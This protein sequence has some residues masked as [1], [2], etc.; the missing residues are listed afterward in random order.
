MKKIWNYLKRHW[1]EDYSSFSYGIIIAMLI[2]LLVTNYSID[3]E[4]NIL[5]TKTGL[6]KFVYYLLFYSIPYY[7]T[8]AIICHKDR[9]WS[10]KFI[11]KSAFG[12]ILLATDASLPFLRPMLADVDPK[13]YLWTY[14]VTVNLISLFTICLP[15]F[16]YYRLA[17]KKLENFYG[18]TPRK[19][20]YAP[21]LLMLLIMLPLILGATML[22]GFLKQYP[23]YKPNLAHELLGVPSIVT[24]LSYELAYGLDFVTVELFFRGF[25]VIGMAT[26]LGRKSVL[27]MA[28]IYCLLHFGKP[29]GE[30]MSSVVGGYIL[31]VIAFETKS[32]WGGVIV[33]VGI[34]WMMELVSYIARH[35]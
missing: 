20:D 35:Y 19:F 28:V 27:A 23:M 16:V 24:A 29:A 25:M 30:A 10:G 33:H 11:F 7:T 1:S 13:L 12:L 5:D 15:L 8:V 17:D 14:K 3:F 18:L 9:I 32:I 2:I 22:P 31:G 34:A 21:Y 4:D 6:T 26:L